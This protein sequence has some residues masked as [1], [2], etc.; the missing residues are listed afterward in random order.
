VQDSVLFP[1]GWLPFQAGATMVLRGGG[2]SG[3]G[4][5]LPLTS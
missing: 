3:F 2:G 5:P 1:A 4:L